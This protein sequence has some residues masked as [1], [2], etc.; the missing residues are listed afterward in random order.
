MMYIVNSYDE[1]F[2]LYIYTYERSGLLYTFY[3]TGSGMDSFVMY[4]IELA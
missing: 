3:C 2:Q 1:D 4:A